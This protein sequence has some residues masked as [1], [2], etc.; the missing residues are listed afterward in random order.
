V[1]RGTTARAAPFDDVAGALAG[2]V[3]EHLLVRE[4]RL[5]SGAPVDRRLGAVGEAGLEQRVK[6][7]WLKRMYSGSWLRI[8]RRQS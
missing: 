6:I 1:I 3:G 5:A 4:H 8:S 2:A 7:T